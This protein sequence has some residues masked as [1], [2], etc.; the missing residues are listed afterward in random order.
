MKVQPSYCHAMSRVTQHCR[1]FS[2]IRLQN[3]STAARVTSRDRGKDAFG[4]L[5]SAEVEK[6]DRPCK[7]EYTVDWKESDSPSAA[8]AGL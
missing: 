4:E 8:S 3:H 1:R 7:G 2:S 6:R 5:S